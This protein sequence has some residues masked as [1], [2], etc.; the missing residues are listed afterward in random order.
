MSIEQRLRELNVKLP[1]LTVNK[2]PFDLGV[3]AENMVYLSG[4]TPTV[5]GELKYT[6]TVGSTISIEEAKEAAVLCT[7]N[8]LAALKTLIPDLN[9]VQRIV[10]VNGYVASE[11][12][13][14][15]Q[16]Q[17]INAAS[18]LLNDIF[19]PENSHARAAVGTAALPG[20]AAVEIE[21]IVQLKN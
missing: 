1:V 13:F 8:L 4:Q 16:P 20:G 17:V 6:G 14:H 7:L 11:K 10:K 2:A 21:M 15:E 9:H 5:N 12:D 18:R 19:G 3:I